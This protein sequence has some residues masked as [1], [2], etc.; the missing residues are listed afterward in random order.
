MTKRDKRALHEIH[1]YSGI[2][3]DILRDWDIH[4]KGL[5]R[6]RAQCR[7][8][9]QRRQAIIAD[10]HK[11]R[12]MPRDYILHEIL[13]IC[14]GAVLTAGSKKKTINAEENFVSTLAGVI[15]ILEKEAFGKH[16]RKR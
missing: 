13:H 15:S 1:F 7:I 9:P 11:G 16:G 3:E 2:F 6:R 4:W 8:D 10:W 14:V 12:P 5:G